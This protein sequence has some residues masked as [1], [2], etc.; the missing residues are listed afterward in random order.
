M[1]LRVRECLI[2]RYLGIACTDSLATRTN[3]KKREQTFRDA[4]F[5]H[6]VVLKI[7]NFAEN[8]V[9]VIKTFF[10]SNIKYFS[11]K[12]MFGLEESIAAG[13]TSFINEFSGS[14]DRSPSSVRILR[15]IIITINHIAVL[16]SSH[17]ISRSSRSSLPKLFL[18]IAR[19]CSKAERESV[20][21]EIN[22]PRSRLTFTV[23][24]P[25]INR[26]TEH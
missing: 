12:M 14:R 20:H 9:F 18:G 6:E 13:T 17:S 7:N 1:R 8:I 3:G 10:L 23:L 2:L 4:T 25:H 21:Y 22:D 5:L 24:V 19:G 26:I 11:K 16:W 15:N